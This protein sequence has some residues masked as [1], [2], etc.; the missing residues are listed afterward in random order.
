MHAPNTIHGVK[1][2]PSMNL[3]K[4]AFQRRDT[5]PK[6]ARTTIGSAPTW[7]TVPKM[8]EVMKMAE[9]GKVSARDPGGRREGRALTKAEDP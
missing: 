5:A 3:A 1:T 2:S 7:K 6:G 8:L 9:K 4:R